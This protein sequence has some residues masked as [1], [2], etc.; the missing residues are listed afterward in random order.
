MSM[1]TILICLV[2]GILTGF[3]VA[4]I[5]KAQLKSVRPENAAANYV[6]G[7]SLQLTQCFDMYLYSNVT[8]TPIPKNDNRSK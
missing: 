5:L 8:K 6:I 7:G 4:G 3:L 2:L 1:E